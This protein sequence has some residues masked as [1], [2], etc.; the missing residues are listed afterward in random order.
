MVVSRRSSAPL[1]AAGFVA[2]AIGGVAKADISDLVFYIRAET[3]DGRFAEFEH[4]F[5]PQYFD[6]V[7]GSYDWSLLAP[8]N[9]MAADGSVIAVLNTATETCHEDPDVTL[10]FNVASGAATTTFTI[11]SAL[12]GFSTIAS[13]EGRASASVNATDLD[14]NG[15]ALTPMG[16]GSYTAFYNG[17]APATGTTFANLLLAGASAPF[18]TAS[19][20]DAF[21]PV[22]FSPIVPAVSNM[23][24]QFHFSL[25]SNDVAAGTSFYRVQAIPAPGAVGLL[26]LA[27]LLVSRRRR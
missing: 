25:S 9:M 4:R 3:A 5:D 27:G 18:G 17:V 15:V 19:A 12:L 7:R 20:S 13:A 10:N 2:L 24:A 11:N 6:P 1:V 8:V 21:P 26:G 22:G 14:D 23:S 16:V